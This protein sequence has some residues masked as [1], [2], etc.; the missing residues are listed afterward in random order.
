MRL[1]DAPWTVSL[2]HAGG[3]G[4]LVNRCYE[5]RPDREDL[6]RIELQERD[7]GVRTPAG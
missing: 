4:G 2:F 6:T 3:R 1:P 7:R 5:R